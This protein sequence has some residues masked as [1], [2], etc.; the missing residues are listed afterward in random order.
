MAVVKVIRYTTSPDAADENARLVGE[1]F[2][3]LATAAPTGLRYVTFRLDDE[4]SFIHVA[5]LDDEDDNPLFRTPAFSRFLE[6][7]GTR[8]ADGPV[9]VDGTVVGSY[10]MADG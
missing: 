6:D 8:V 9:T 10:R 5:L 2:E 4:V 3:E 1:V 7:L